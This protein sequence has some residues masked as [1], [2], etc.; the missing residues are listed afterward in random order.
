M[1]LNHMGQLNKEWLKKVV[2]LWGHSV[3][4]KQP[5]PSFSFSLLCH[6]PC[7]TVVQHRAVNWIRELMETLKRSRL[8]R[9]VDTEKKIKARQGLLRQAKLSAEMLVKTWT[10]WV[11]MNEIIKLF[12]CILLK[13]YEQQVRQ[14][15]GEL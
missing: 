4:F 12:K 13:H 3:W 7:E 8:R 15:K 10:D 14:K 1:D 9:I 2:V 11:L 5:L 6:L